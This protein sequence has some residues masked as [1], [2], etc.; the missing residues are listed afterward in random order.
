MMN[1]LSVEFII[2]MREEKDSSLYDKFIEKVIQHIGA[3]D[4]SVWDVSIE[5]VVQTIKDKDCRYITGTGDSNSDEDDDD[6]DVTGPIDVMK[7]V[8]DTIT[9]CFNHLT[10]AH[11]MLKEAFIE[12][13]HLVHVL[14]KRGLALLLEAIAIGS[15]V[16]DTKAFNILQ[17]AKV[18]QRIRDEIKAQES[19]MCTIDLRL[20]KHK[21]CMLPNWR[22]QIFYNSTKCVKIGKVAAAIIVYLRFALRER[23]RDV[24][25]TTVGQQFAIGQRNA[26]KVVT[27]KIYDSEEKRVENIFEKTRKAYPDDP[28]DW[29]EEVANASH[30][31]QEKVIYEFYHQDGENADLPMVGASTKIRDLKPVSDILEQMPNFPRSAD[32]SQIP[33][34]RVVFNQSHPFENMVVS[35][36]ASK[37]AREAV[38]RPVGIE[39]ASTSRRTKESQV[40]P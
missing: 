12:A 23:P 36:V 33:K 11:S 9:K 20:E 7:T 22:Y 30:I 17:D 2:R 24:P 28:I 15:I 3:V 5:D 31:T 21:N 40:K 38:Y 18:H 14:P 25:L 19:K 6:N 34:L 29:G 27:G 39:T 1:R 26:R 13:G 16:Q 8:H 4:T 35:K 37:E 10:E 32:E